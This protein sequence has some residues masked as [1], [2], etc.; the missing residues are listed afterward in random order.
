LTRLIAAIVSLP[1]TLIC[2]WDHN[3]GTLG[4]VADERQEKK[5]RYPLKKQILMT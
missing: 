1:L 5:D 2:G 3:I 4:T